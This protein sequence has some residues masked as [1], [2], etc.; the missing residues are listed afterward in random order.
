MRTGGGLRVVLH[1]EGE[2]TAV[3]VLE[4]ETL[5][6]L[7]T[8]IAAADLFDMSLLSEIYAADP[9]LIVKG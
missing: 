7:G 3:V 8:E 4:G 9:S 2:Q 5:A 6:A 1:G